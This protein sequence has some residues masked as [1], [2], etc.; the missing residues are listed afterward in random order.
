MPL[1]YMIF[2]RI[3]SGNSTIAGIFIFNLQIFPLFPLIRTLPAVNSDYLRI[4]CKSLF[5]RN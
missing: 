5:N 1:L 3:A 4:I 2:P